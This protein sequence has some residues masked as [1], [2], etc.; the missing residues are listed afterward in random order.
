MNEVPVLRFNGS[1]YDIYLMKQYLHK[2][3]SDI[4]ETVSF[5]I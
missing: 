4:K 1:K 2:S 3:L 5:A